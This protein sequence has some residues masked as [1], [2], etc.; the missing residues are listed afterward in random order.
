VI[1]ARAVSGEVILFGKGPVQQ[2]GDDGQ[3]AALIVGGQ[4]HRVLVANSHV[5]VCDS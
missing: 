5:G 4:Q 1:D 3:I 2:P